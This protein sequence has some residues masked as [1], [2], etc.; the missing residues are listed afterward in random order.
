MTPYYMEEVKFSHEE[1]HS[2]Q[3]GASILSYM[4]KIY[5]GTFGNGFVTNIVS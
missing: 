3:D 1:L 4:Q 5:P 2:S